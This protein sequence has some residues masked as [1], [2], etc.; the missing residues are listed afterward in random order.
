[1]KILLTGGGT[2]GHVIPHIAMMD[3]FKKNFD[4]II[5]I[6]SHD[7]I[8]NSLIKSRSDVVYYPITTTKLVRGK[9]LTNLFIPFKLVKGVYQAKRIIK[10]E[11]PNVVFSKG[12]FVSLPVV[13]AAKRLKVPVVAHESDLNMGLANR[14]SKRSAKVICTTFEKTADSIKNKGVYVGS[15]LKT[16]MFKDKQRAK[17]NLGIHTQKP[18]LVVTG[19]SLGAKALNKQIRDNLKQLT[20]TF[21]VLHITG[22]NNLDP[23]LK[24]LTDYK[25]I[26]FSND[27]GSVLSSADIVVSRAGSNTIFEIAALKKPMLLVPLPKGNSRGDQVD[28]AKYFNQKGYANFVTEDQL[29]SISIVTPIMQTYNERG[30]LID[31]LT[32]ANIEPGNKKLLE[33]IMQNV[34]A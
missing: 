15:P 3:D 7:G 22:K 23:T 29:D 4:T 34:K 30:K 1:M 28:N 19:G 6:G 24:I 14:L 8:E 33:V 21:F 18:V 10:N 2:A 13:L 27:M 16:D 12:G 9:I 5:Y 31:N 20:K 26:E 25:Q 17:E 11:K 32:K